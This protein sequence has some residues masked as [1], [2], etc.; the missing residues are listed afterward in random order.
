MEKEKNFD[1]LTGF[2]SLVF[3]L[4]YAFMVSQTP[5]ANFGDPN[6]HLYFPYGIAF[7]FIILGLLL[8]IKG[9]IKPS[10][11]AVKSLLNEDAVKKQDRKRVLYTCILSLGYALGFEHLGYVLSTSIFM[12]L[13][14]ALMNGL[15]AWKINITISLLF[16]FT[17][18]LIFSK[19]LGIS[20][21]TLG[22]EIGGITW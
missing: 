10:I 2:V 9:G 21:P 6:A 17:V 16:S 15:K 22:I 8:L 18:F 3:G 5:K 7:L 20:L 19:F 12:F 14:L 13:V 11:N 1:A 4:A